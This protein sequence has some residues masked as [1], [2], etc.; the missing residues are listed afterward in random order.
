MMCCYG[1]KSFAADA[2]AVGTSN[3]AVEGT[4]TEGTKSLSL[5]WS[6][7][8]GVTHVIIENEKII[9]VEHGQECNPCD[10]GKQVGPVVL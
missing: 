5:D 4:G 6:F 10:D 7:P 3:G 1:A 2:A 9:P 8:S